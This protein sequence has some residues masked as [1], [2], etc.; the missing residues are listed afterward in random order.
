M[1]KVL[2]RLQHPNPKRPQ[3][4]P[5][6]WSV[7]AYGKRLQM[8]PDPDEIDILDKKASKRIQSTLLNM[9]YYE[10]SVYPTMLREINKILRV[11]SRPTRDTAEKARMLLDY[12]ATYLNVILSYKGIYIVLHVDSDSAYLTMPK[13]RSC[14][15]GHFYLSNWPS[16]S[17]IKPN[18]A[19]NDPIHAECK[20]NLKI[21]VLCSRI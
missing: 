19:R 3:Y 15:S 14:Y 16:P 8:A 9:L 13:T 11:Q 17:P 2:D 4:V 18:P 6:C 7:P 10:Q 5:H 20:T 12:A 1:R 21:C